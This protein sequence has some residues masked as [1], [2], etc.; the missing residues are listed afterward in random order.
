M[1]LIVTEPT[2]SGEHDLERIV[3]LTRHFEV[4]AA[5]CI[6]KWDINPEM[7]ARIEDK[8]RAGGC[9]IA[10]RIRYD[11]SV[12]AAQLREQ[13]VVESDSPAGVDIREI[14]KAIEQH[15]GGVWNPVKIGSFRR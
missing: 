12:T 7:A 4:P 9:L 14:W 6:N 1:A 10:G 11:P 5:V 8:A 3:S 15:Q 2:R 13:A